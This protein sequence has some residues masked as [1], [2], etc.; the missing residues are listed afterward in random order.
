MHAGNARPAAARRIRAEK[1]G[2]DWRAHIGSPRTDK[3]GG[4]GAADAPPHT[5]R[6][7]SEPWLAEVP[8][9]IIRPRVINEPA[10]SEALA[11]HVTIDPLPSVVEPA[12]SAAPA[13]TE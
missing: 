5:S 3:R 7:A 6:Q 1:L 13:A 8:A 2:A 4:A 10:S 11:A 9:T 12:S